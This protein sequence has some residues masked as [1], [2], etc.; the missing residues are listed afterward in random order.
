[1][2]KNDLH[3][4]MIIV[5]NDNNELIM[6]TPKYKNEFTHKE[7]QQL[8]ENKYYIGCACKGI[9]KNKDLSFHIRNNYNR[10]FFI[11]NG[12]TKQNHSE[13]CP[14]YMTEEELQ[15]ERKYNDACHMIEDENGEQILFM[16]TSSCINALKPR[17]SKKDC[18]YIK[19]SKRHSATTNGQCTFYGM[20]THALLA[21]TN[22][23][24]FRYQGVDLLTDEGKIIF[25]KNFYQLLMNAEINIRHEKFS[26]CLKKND[27]NILC[28]FL[29]E[30]TEQKIDY[31]MIKN[32]ELKTVSRKINSKVYED[33]KQDYSSHYNGAKLQV[34]EG[35]LFFFAIEYTQNNNRRIIQKSS[36]I[37]LSR[38]AIWCESK[39]EELYYNLIWKVVREYNSSKR[40]LIFYKPD[41]AD[42]KDVYDGEYRP[43]GKLVYVR[44]PHKE[45]YVEIFGRNDEEYIKRKMAKKEK[46]SKNI[47]NVGFVEWNAVEEKFDEE[48]LENELKT[49]MRR[50][51]NKQKK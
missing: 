20:L 40:K 45:L 17:S 30:A 36:I 37:R 51:W 23:N 9:E 11:C 29:V 48:K 8:H 32:G 5:L 47:E 3:N 13:F 35:I 28:G 10:Y 21:T 12:G 31:Q 2:N 6:E 16:R 19:R 33:L 42:P 50:L 49:E 26:E 1:M 25:L 46:I 43:D 24:I 34:G 15:K 27:M 18:N 41:Q 4:P 22:R 44:A 38:G 7:K 14:A 39:H